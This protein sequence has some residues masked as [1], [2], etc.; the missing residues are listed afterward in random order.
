MRLGATMGLLSMMLRS[1][2]LRYACFAFV[3]DHAQPLQYYTLAP[4]HRCAAAMNFADAEAGQTAFD[5]EPKGDSA[6][7]LPFEMEVGWALAE[8]DLI[9]A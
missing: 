9:F 7:T 2:F 3:V 8:L 5:K 6:G 4:L 1:I